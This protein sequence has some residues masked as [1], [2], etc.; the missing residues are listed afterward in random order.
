MLEQLMLN[1]RAANAL[2]TTPRP[3]EIFDLIGGTSTGGLNALLVG[4][5]GLSAEDAILEYAKLSKKVFE[6][7]K[8]K[9]KDGAFK[10]TRMEEAV[11]QLIEDKGGPRI[12]PGQDSEHRPKG[13]P[14]LTLLDP[15][16]GNSTCKT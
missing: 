12:Q 7:R 2:D 3:A 14:K 9:G 15:R 8:P 10:A 11:E 13:D 1:I 16:T 6:E 5:L 4:R